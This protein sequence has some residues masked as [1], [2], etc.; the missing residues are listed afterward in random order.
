MSLFR[1]CCRC[2]CCCWCQNTE[3]L[4]CN[5]FEEAVR[6]PK[7]AQCN[8]KFSASPEKMHARL[9]LQ[10]IHRCFRFDF[11]QKFNGKI[12][13][14][15]KFLEISFSFSHWGSFGKGKNKAGSCNETTGWSHSTVPFRKLSEVVYSRAPFHRLKNGKPFSELLSLIKNC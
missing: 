6:S 4:S 12:S 9:R 10:E 8:S 3:L 15:M 5:A 14:K 13:L 7:D 11:S 2:W 1:F